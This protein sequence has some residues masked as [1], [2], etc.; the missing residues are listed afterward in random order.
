MSQINRLFG[1]TTTTPVS[2]NGKQVAA[3]LDTG[4]NVSTIGKSYYELNLQN[5][6]TPLIPLDDLLNIEV[7]TGDRLP[8]LGYGGSLLY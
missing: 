3:L 8:Y 7:A 6:S 2:V 5:S 4:S 1:N